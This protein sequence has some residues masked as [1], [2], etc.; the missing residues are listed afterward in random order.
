MVE[1]L[2][3]FAKHSIF[4]ARVPYFLPNFYYQP[5]DSPSKTMKNVFYFI[6]KA[7]FV[8]EIFKFLYFR[9]PLFFSQSAITLEV[10]GR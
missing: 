4:K 6:Q 10:V 9:L 1:P 7:L 5:N 2:I 8:F 3:I